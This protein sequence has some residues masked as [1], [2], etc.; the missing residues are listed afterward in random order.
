MKDSYQRSFSVKSF[1]ERNEVGKTTVYGEINTGRLRARKAGKRTII[2][3]EDEAEWLKNLPVVE[4][5][6]SYEP[7]RKA[8]AVSPT[9]PDAERRPAPKPLLTRRKTRGPS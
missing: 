2:T 1:C 9:S 8:E 3:D 4:P 5:K 6:S 7:K